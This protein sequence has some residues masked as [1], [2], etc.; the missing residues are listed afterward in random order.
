MF[1]I[2]QVVSYV[3]HYELCEPHVKE[4]IEILISVYEMMRHCVADAGA[5][6]FHL[7]H[8]DYTKAT[9]RALKAEVDE[10][11]STMK[12]RTVSISMGPCACRR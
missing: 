6:T 3:D 5:I 4:I 12:P 11:V 8:Q 7:T 10:R 1:C 2:M 9:K